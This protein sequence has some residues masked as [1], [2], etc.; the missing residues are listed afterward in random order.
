MPTIYDEH[1]WCTLSCLSIAG[2][3][4]DIEPKSIFLLLYWQCLLSCIDSDDRDLKTGPGWTLSRA[5]STQLH[6]RDPSSSFPASSW[7]SGC[8]IEGSL[9]KSC[10]APKILST[11]AVAQLFHVFIHQLI[12]YPTNKVMETCAPPHVRTYV[13]AC[14]C[15]W[16][17]GI[18]THWK[19]ALY[20]KG[21]V[22]RLPWRPLYSTTTLSQPG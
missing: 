11:T 16:G 18:L 17:G 5:S 1:L 8:S 10:L 3:H 14:V 22:H 12:S 19:I 20:P 15:M 7:Q 9:D 4:M 21:T 2:M 13:H 6:W